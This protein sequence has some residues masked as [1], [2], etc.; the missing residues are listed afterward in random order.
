MKIQ[1]S[2]KALLEFES[3]K[4]TNI[5]RMRVVDDDIEIICHD[6]Q[7]EYV[8]LHNNGTDHHEIFLRSTCKQFCKVSSR[9][10]KGINIVG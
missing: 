9:K 3:R 2:F 1:E 5:T 4:C 10:P 8:S 7:N 6:S